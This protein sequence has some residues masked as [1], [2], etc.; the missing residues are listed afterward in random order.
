MIC[1]EKADSKLHVRQ[2][3]RAAGQAEDGED[4]ASVH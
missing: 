4:I 3:K 1:L 2:I